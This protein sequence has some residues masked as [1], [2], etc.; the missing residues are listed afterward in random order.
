MLKHLSSW[1]LSLIGL[2]CMAFSSAAQPIASNGILDARDFNFSSERLNL[3]GTWIMYDQQ[4][5]G[6]G[7]IE[8]GD[9]I[10]SA[11]PQTWNDI[12]N[13]GQGVAS[14]K[15]TVLVNTTAD[16]AFDLPQIYSSYRLWVN[17]ELVAMNG[18]PGATAAETKP[19]W[20][21]QTTTFHVRG[22]SLVLVL[23]IANFHHHKGGIKDP[24]YLGESSNMSAQHSLSTI[25]KFI[26]CGVLFIVAVVFF[27][28]YLQQ[29]FKKVV[30]YFSL[31][32][33]TWSVRSVFSNDYTFISFFP[34]FSWAAMVRIEYITLYL[35]MM[36]AI[37]YLGRVFTKE[38]S[39][40]IKYLLVTINGAFLAYTVFATTVEFTRLLPVYL[41][42][43]AVVLVYGA[44]VVL[45]A[46]IN[47]RLGAMFLTISVILGLITFSYDIFTY[48][49]LFTYNS[50]LF[51][52]GYIVIFSLMAVAL[53]IKL[54]IIKTANKPTT[55]LT[56]KDLYGD[57]T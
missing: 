40:I 43:S 23:Q 49:G 12:R 41:V 21:P 42:T 2:L 44:A 30:L 45:M 6:P 28:L 11:F 14:Y 52:A 9:G 5:L 57:K 7:E 22:D 53:L 27:L 56:Y 26:E 1:Q 38:G 48:E 36:W 54:E 37:L 8:N 4:L 25:S 10:P 19:Q 55:M 18:I 33:L 51:S 32:C 16:L 20:M 24:I 46:L 31:L 15:L 39:P 34:D 47:E 35:T 50:L 17:N 3:T 29:G 13:D